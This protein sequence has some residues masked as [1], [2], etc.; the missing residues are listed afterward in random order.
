M[1]DSDP[2]IY[3]YM[4]RG[5]KVPVPEL[6]RYGSHY[7]VSVA[8]VSAVLNCSDSS[9]SSTPAATA[10]VKRRTGGKGRGASATAALDPDELDPDRDI[11]RPTNRDTAHPRLSSMASQNLDA[12]KRSTYSSQCTLHRDRSGF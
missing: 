9:G 2:F 1:L 12:K 3:R 6:E 10:A 7:P 11:T 4:F 5:S 8:P